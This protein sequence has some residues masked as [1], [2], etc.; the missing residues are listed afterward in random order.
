MSFDD[1]ETLWKA[2]LSRTPEQIQAAWEALNGEERIAIYVH[3]KRMA[4]EEGWTE[5]QRI[6]AQSAL[7]VLGDLADQA[8]G[9]D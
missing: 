5:P 2:L 4:S 9:E 7:D 3:L 1:V 6:S 8:A